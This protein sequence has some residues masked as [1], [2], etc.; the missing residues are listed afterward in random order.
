MNF[1]IR[2]NLISSI[3]FD[4]LERKK[5]KIAGFDLDHTLIKPKKNIHPKS[6]D[7][8]ELV[9]PNVIEYL[10]N[11]IND[12]Y[13]IV[14]FSNQS[15]LN[16]KLEKKNIVLGRIDKLFNLV[17]SPKF[18]ILL[19]TKNDHLRKPNTGMWDLIIEKLN[20]KNIKI[21][22]NNSF[23]VGD[24]AGRFKTSKKKKDFSCSDRMF[25]LNN[26]INFFT[27]ENYFLG[28]DVR[29]KKKEFSC[30]NKSFELFDIKK[31]DID[32]YKNTLTKIKKFNII[33]LIGPPGSGKSTLGN[34]FTNYIVLNQDTLKTK[35]K[36]FEK[37]RSLL[38]NNINEKIILDNLN[39]TISYR[40]T[41]TDYLKK[42][43]INFC[44][45]IFD[46]NKEQSF[47]LNNFRAKIMKRERLPDV[48][49]HTYFKRYQNTNINEGYTDLFNLNFIPKFDNKK[50]EELFYEYY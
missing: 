20:K 42:E 27:P 47:I 24:A 30:I 35:Y 21:D 45:V 16:N 46:I 36:V 50:E 44:Y 29:D 23:Y 13:L 22:M 32:N 31:K 14:I 41:F 40:K 33:F 5:V 48:V 18:N 7:D 6:I 3:N 19:S 49:I 37:F 39:N 2:N 34:K 25:A 4:N 15:D 43:N 38:K 9:F 1:N 12:D 10:N 8:F 26:N 17:K 11:L 28:E